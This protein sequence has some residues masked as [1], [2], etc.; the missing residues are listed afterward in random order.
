MVFVELGDGAFEHEFTAGDLQL[1]EIGGAREQHAPAIFDER[2]SDG[3]GEM[4]LAS[5][6]RRKSRRLAPCPIQPSPEASAMTW[7]L[8]IRAVSKSKASSDFPAAGALQR[9]GVSMRRR[10]RSAVSCSAEEA[11]CRL[12]FL[13]GLL[14]ELCPHHGRV[15]RISRTLYLRH[16]GLACPA[17]RIRCHCR[18]LYAQAARGW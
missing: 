12:A 7:A 15:H 9:D 1:H 13:I 18:I 2:Q 4:T 10:A 16:N 11:G 5:R 14:R 8:L 17:S 6:G 3:D